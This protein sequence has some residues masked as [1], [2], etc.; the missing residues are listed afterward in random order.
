MYR[1]CKHAGDMDRRRDREQREVETDSWRTRENK[2]LCSLL[3]HHHTPRVPGPAATAPAR[4]GSRLLLSPR[5]QEQRVDCGPHG[6]Q[7]KGIVNKAKERGERRKQQRKKLPAAHIKTENS[8][9]VGLISRCCQERTGSAKP[10]PYSF[11]TAGMCLSTL[12]FPPKERNNLTFLGCH[13]P[14][15]LFVL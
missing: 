8:D 11:P 3:G 1:E 9:A 12:L 2:K 6:S 4:L 13:S 14:P 10:E 7:D 5:P 15:F